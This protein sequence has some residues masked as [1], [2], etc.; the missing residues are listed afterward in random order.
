MGRGHKSCPVCGAT[1]G[2]R[3]FQCVCGHAFKFKDEKPA[4][5]V[6]IDGTQRV[7]NWRELKRYDRI[8][9]IAGS[10]P[11]FPLSDGSKEPIGY[12]GK[13]TVLFIDRNGIYAY[14]NKKEGPSAR[15]YIWMGEKM[16]SDAGVVRRPHKIIK[17]KPAKERVLV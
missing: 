10:G 11:Y 17:L 12:R 14:G 7:F 4:A 13:F 2:P 8:K 6:K 16:T 3:A 15:C 9:V 5:S 1:T